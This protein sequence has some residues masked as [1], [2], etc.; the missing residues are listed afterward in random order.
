MNVRNGWQTCEAA[1]LEPRQIVLDS[2]RG[3]ELQLC[4]TTQDKVR[5]ESVKK[6]QPSQMM[7]YLYSAGHLECGGQWVGQVDEIVCGE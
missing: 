3:V 5:L 4:V 1:G 6:K 7:F 2:C